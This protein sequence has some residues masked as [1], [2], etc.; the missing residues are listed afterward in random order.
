MPVA[1]R[2]VMDSVDARLESLLKSGLSPALKKAV[3]SHIKDLKKAGENVTRKGE[4]ILQ[5]LK[6]EY[7][8]VVYVYA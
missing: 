2:K 1:T 8:A 7:V 6:D 3:N 5:Y 4:I